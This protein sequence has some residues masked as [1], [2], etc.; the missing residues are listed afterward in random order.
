MPLASG[1]GPVLVTVQLR[2]REGQANDRLPQLV[3]WSGLA[4]LGRIETWPRVA[5]GVSPPVHH[6]AGD[7]AGGI[8]AGARE[9]L[10]HLLANLGFVRLVARAEQARATGVTLLHERQ[11]I[12]IEGDVEGEKVR[13]VG[14]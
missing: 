5:I 2:V 10:D 9:Q 6:D 1:D 7:V 12:L 4:V 3:G 14:V 11:A 8:E 13:L